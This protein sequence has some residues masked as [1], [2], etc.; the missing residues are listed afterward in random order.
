MS[1]AATLGTLPEWDLSDLYDGPADPRIEQDMAA[2]ISEARSFEADLKGRVGNLKG[3]EFAAA[4]VRYEA[5]EDA[6]GR[7][8]SYA[9]LLFAGD[10][11]DSEKGRFYQGVQE[12]LTDATSHLIFLSLEINRIED[13]VME[14]LVRDPVVAR[15]RP[16]LNEVR[17]FRPHQL[18]DDAEAMLHELSVVQSQPW[19]RLF[20]QT[21]AGL[22]FEIDG[23]T[24]TE[25]QALDLLSSS[26]PAKRE[27]S[28][29]ELARVF[30]ANESL[31]ALIT[32]TLAKS[33]SIED[34]WRH[35]ARPISSRNLANQV[36]DE[37]VEALIDAVQKSY[38]S[39]SHRYYALKARWMGVGKL[40]WWDRNA[41][42][43][44]DD[45]RQIP[46][47]E[48]RATVLG[49]Y[50]DF[51]PQMAE[52]AGVFFDEGWIDAP[53]REGKAGGAFAHP[54]VPS[55]HPYVLLNYQGKTRDV[56]TLAHELGHGVHQVLAAEQGPLLAD[57]PLTL[58]ETASVFGEQLAFRRMLDAEDDP[59]RRRMVL[60]AKVED[61]L[62]TVVRQV[63]FCEFE[64]RLHDARAQGELTP[65]QI[66]DIWMAVQVESLG[67]VFAFDDDYRNFWSYIPHFIH[68]PFYVYAYAFG[69]CL[70][71]ALYAHYQEA[72]E[73][74]QDRFFTMLKAGGSQRHQ[75]LLAPFGLDASDPDFWSMGLK[76][77]EGFIDEL[78]AAEG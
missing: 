37:V 40:D 28:A 45:D 34:G 10:Q 3:A 20:D 14:G 30:K 31:F 21:I 4:I 44:N 51:A 78:E 12:Q 8:A 7:V 68:S 18:S 16:W 48:A 26:D 72:E 60:A 6:M 42:L 33:K 54:T 36:E 50:G 41:P 59:Q 58:A 76:V 2:A 69:D 35:F 1:S 5:M 64:R 57:T 71:N 74:F 9:Q 29:R 61:M 38:P 15:Y 63:A 53:V 13:H 55:A 39:L 32:N 77:I 17:S 75:E 43:P 62:N 22:R 70:V 27:A 73:G 25:A 11:S 49:A 56:M 67:P 24:L 23:E 19:V 46:W 66:G 47:D 65:D 52:I